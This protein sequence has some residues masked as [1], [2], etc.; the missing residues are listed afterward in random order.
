MGIILCTGD[1]MMKKIGKFLPSKHQ[2]PYSGV[3]QVQLLIPYSY[4]FYHFVC[5]F[6]SYFHNA[7]SMSPNAKQ[8]A[9]H[10]Q[11]HKYL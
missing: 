8:T 9:C 10:K 2:F 6:F 5:L 1:F 11:V 3:P 4:L 7:Q